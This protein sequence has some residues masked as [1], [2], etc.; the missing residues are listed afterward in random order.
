MSNSKIIYLKFQQNKKKH[1]RIIRKFEIN[2]TISQAN[3]KL[4]KKRMKGKIASRLFNE[5]LTHSFNNNKKTV[6]K[7]R[8]KKVQ[9]PTKALKC[10]FKRSRSWSLFGETNWNHCDNLTIF[11]HFVF[12]FISCLVALE[13]SNLKFIALC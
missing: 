11:L 13:I 9:M 2:Q 6:E 4:K 12:F 10:A 5:Y 1:S 7:L 3:H 8:T